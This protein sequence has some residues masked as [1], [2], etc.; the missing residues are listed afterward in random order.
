M[1]FRYM[2]IT[3]TFPIFDINFIEQIDQ[4]GLHLETKG[5]F[6][7]Y[8]FFFLKLNFIIYDLFVIISFNK[9]FFL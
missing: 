9:F 3:N 5:Q 4:Q 2:E 1:I 8:F 6:I 7:F